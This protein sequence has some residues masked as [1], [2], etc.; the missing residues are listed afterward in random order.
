MQRRPPRWHK[1]RSLRRCEA[2]VSE[3]IGYILMFFLSSAILML[4]MQA[5]LYSRNTTDDLRTATELKLISERLSGEVAQA[6]LV[7][8]D[9]PDAIYEAT[10][11]LPDMH[12]VSYYVNASGGQVWANT[13]DGRFQANS[14]AF[15]IDA[16][17]NPNLVLDGTVYSSQGYAKVHYEKQGNLRVVSL[18]I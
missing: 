16:L 12:G 3:V 10:V 18:T 4:S 6:G 7:A 9:M 11:I 15:N 1:P 17:L 14:T 8:S 13:T 2:A 5:F